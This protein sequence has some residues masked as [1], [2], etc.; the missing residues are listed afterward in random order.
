[1]NQAPHKESE[2]K[3]SDAVF[4]SFQRLTLETTGIDL[5]SS[6]RAMLLTRFN[7]RL[8]S[9]RLSSFEEYLELVLQP[10]HPER[11]NF[12]DTV[13]TNL[14]YFFREPHHFDVLAKTVF[15]KL[16]NAGNVTAPVRVWSAGCSS[17]QEPYSIAITA[18]QSGLTSQ[19]TIRILCTDI[20]SKMVQQTQQGSF[21]FEE[22]RGLSEEQRDRWFDK[23]SNGQWKADTVL[24]SMLICRELNLFGPWPVRPGIDVIICRNVLIYFDQDRQ[25]NLIKG[26]AAVQNSGAHLFIGHSETMKGCEKLY[27]RVDNTVYER[28]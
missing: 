6:K 27:R 14:T 8:K 2:G 22:L 18:E 17:G 10:D 19:R 12:I 3:M 23:Q 1:M 15:S 13:T 5:G 9:L 16:K 4:T 26:F 21:T 24:R 11:I 7:R 20:H 25:T 28:I